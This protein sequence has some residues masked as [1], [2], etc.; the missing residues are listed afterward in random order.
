MTGVE[1]LQEVKKNDVFQNIPVIFV[2]TESSDTRIQEAKELGVAA[3]V[4]KPFQ[5]AMIKDILL[6]V[7]NKAYAKR[8]EEEGVGAAPIEDDSDLDF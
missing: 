5:P 2:T 1:F 8:M 3:Y 6:D 4:K 7:L